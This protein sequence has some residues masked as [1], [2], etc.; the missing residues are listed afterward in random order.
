MISPKLPLLSL[1]VAFSL[2]VLPDPARAD[3]FVTIEARE[4]YNSVAVSPT[5]M[6]TLVGGAFDAAFLLGISATTGAS[7]KLGLLNTA[8]GSNAGSAVGQTWTGLTELY[9][10]V[11]TRSFNTSATLRITKQGESFLSSPVV[12]PTNDGGP[13]EISVETSTDSINWVP[14]APGIIPANSPLGFWRLKAKEIDGPGHGPM[15]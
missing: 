5:D 13:I 3:Q 7:L 14:A 11:G 4:G 9:L 2:A 12:L 1:L 15:N 10:G 6:V 8:T